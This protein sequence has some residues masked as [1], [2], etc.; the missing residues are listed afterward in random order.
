MRAGPKGSGSGWRSGFSLL[1]AVVAVAIFGIALAAI[2]P[3]FIY[4]AQTNLASQRKT[5]AVVVAQRVVDGLRQTDF[6]LWP[7]S[8]TVSAA[9]AGGSNFQVALTYCTGSL[10]LCNDGARHLRVEVSQG[11]KVYYRVETVYTTFNSEFN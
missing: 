9:D 8:G 1:E 2:V 4:Y 11:G 6:A 5:E 10:T 7:A 3:A